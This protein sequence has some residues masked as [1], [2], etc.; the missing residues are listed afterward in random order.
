MVFFEHVDEI[1]IYHDRVEMDRWDVAV[2]LAEYPELRAS[3][4][5][6]DCRRESWRLR[7]CRGLKVP[8]EYSHMGNS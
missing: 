8:E 4:W 6:P 5:K 2:H 3:Q 7:K 1:V